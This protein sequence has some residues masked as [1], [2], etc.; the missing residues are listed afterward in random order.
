[1]FFWIALIV[2]FVLLLGSIPAYPYS[3]TWGYR[4]SGGF[5]VLL[6]ALVALAWWF[7]WLPWSTPAY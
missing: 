4:P 7:S 6:L 5:L 3:R 1:M 2:L